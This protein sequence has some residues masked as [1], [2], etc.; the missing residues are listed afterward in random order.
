[1]SIYGHFW[2]RSPRGIML[3]IPRESLEK[4]IHDVYEANAFTVT[5][6]V[7]SE[8]LLAFAGGVDGGGVPSGIYSVP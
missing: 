6:T 2:F 7:C 5:R 4:C 1:M 8:T 3:Y